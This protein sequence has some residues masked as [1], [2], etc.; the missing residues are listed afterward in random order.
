MVIDRRTSRKSTD[1]RHIDRSPPHSPIVSTSSARG[2][3]KVKPI[4]NTLH[5]PL[6]TP[7]SV[8]SP[9][10]SSTAQGTPHRPIHWEDPACNTLLPRHCPHPLWDRF[11]QDFSQAPPCWQSKAAVQYKP[12]GVS[13]HRP[14]RVFH[15]L[16]SP[17]HTLS[18]R[19]QSP[20]TAPAPLPSFSTHPSTAAQRMAPDS[21]PL[22]HSP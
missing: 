6:P 17:L 12:A 20:F 11:R 18:L 13:Q 1:P 7:Y 16:S 10:S 14:V 22:P 3:P 21:L 8:P 2:H 15:P 5:L 9:H 19:P 4:C